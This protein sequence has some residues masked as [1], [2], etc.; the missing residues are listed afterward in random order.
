MRPL[1][2]LILISAGVA[3]TTRPQ[4]DLLTDLE[5]VEGDKCT[6]GLPL[7]TMDLD[8]VVDVGLNGD[9]TETLDIASETTTTNSSVSILPKFLKIGYG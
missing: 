7:D 9:D 3:L 6:D 2:L 8:Q 5:D 4:E 1:D